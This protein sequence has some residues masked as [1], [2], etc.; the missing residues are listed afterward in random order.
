MWKGSMPDSCHWWPLTPATDDLWPYIPSAACTSLPCLGNRLWIWN[1][2]PYSPVKKEACVLNRVRLC[3]P[4]DYSPPGSSVHGISLARILEWVVLFPPRD[5]PWPR[6]Q[7]RTSSS[8]ASAGRLF[9]TW[10]I[11]E[12]DSP[13][14]DPAYSSHGTVD[15]LLSLVLS[16]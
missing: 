5:L 15:C 11:W 6:D 2:V 8:L 7:T 4:M 14:K 13:A 12:A 9:T 10:A 16:W 1:P 3:D